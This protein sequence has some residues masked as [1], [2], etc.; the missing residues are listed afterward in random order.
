MEPTDKSAPNRRSSAGQES[1]ASNDP[2]VTKNQAEYPFHLTNPRNSREA[3]DYS[4]SA[5]CSALAELCDPDQQW[6]KLGS[7]EFQGQS[8][9]GLVGIFESADQAEDHSCDGV[10]STNEGCWNAAGREAKLSRKDPQH[11]G[12]NEHS[13]GRD[14]KQGHRVTWAEKDEYIPYGDN[15]F[16]LLSF[17]GYL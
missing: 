15:P 12:Y 11:T 9:S 2:E 4:S 10:D 8:A 6:R 5:M 14:F 17:D 7:T 3:D 1:W 16:S 13:S